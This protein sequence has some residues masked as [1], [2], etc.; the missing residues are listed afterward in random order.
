MIGWATQHQSMHLLQKLGLLFEENHVHS[1]D[2]SSVTPFLYLLTTKSESRPPCV[3]SSTHKV[4][5]FKTHKWIEWC[6]HQ[7]NQILPL[8]SFQH[9]THEQGFPGNFS[10]QGSP[11]CQDL[12]HQSGGDGSQPQSSSLRDFTRTQAHVTL[13]W[14]PSLN[15]GW[16]CNNVKIFKNTLQRNMVR[17]CFHLMH[18]TCRNQ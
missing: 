2:N 6:K 1:K 9:L 8:F 14:I 17:I 12:W 15:L 7:D 11:Q 10:Y 5:G 3:S 18:T 16:E 4:W 13:P